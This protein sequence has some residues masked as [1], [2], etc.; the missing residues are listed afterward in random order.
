VVMPGG[1][2]TLDELAE[3]LTLMQTGKSRRVP[4]VLVERAYW[5]GLLDWMRE[6]MVAEGN[7]DA[8]DMDL[9][10]QVDGA[11]EVLSAILK[12]YGGRDYA[13]SKE[14]EDLMFEL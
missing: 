9:M 2:G 6:R 12:H 1:F 8:I 7:I 14:E 11:E 5:E 3:I 10:Q 13:P 4:V